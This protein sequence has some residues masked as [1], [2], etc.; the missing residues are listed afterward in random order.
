MSRLNEILNSPSLSPEGKAVIGAFMNLTYEAAQ[1]DETSKTTGDAV[2]DEAIET[3]RQKG[4]GALAD[5][6]HGVSLAFARVVVSTGTAYAET[7]ATMETADKVKGLFSA[8]G[9]AEGVKNGR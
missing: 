3:L 7:I 6:L 4:E 8:L 5:K 1:V 9:G 2:L